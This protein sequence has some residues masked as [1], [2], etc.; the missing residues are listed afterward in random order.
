M[1]EPPPAEP[2]RPPKSSNP[3]RVLKNPRFARLFSAGVASTAGTAIGQV[4]IVWFVYS[5]TKSAIDVALVGISYFAAITVFSLL[6]GTL[7]DRQDRRRLMILA[8]IGRCATLG[9]MTAVLYVFGFSVFVVLVATFLVGALTTVFQPAERAL[10]PTLIEKDEIADANGLTQ[11][12]TSLAQFVA[13]ATGGALIAAVGALSALGLNSI[14]FLVSAALLAGIVTR[15]ITKGPGEVS[16]PRPG[17][18]ED[19]REGFRYIA[20]NRGLLN[21]TIMSGVENVFLSIFGTFAVIYSTAVLGDNATA[22]GAFVALF[23]LGIGL[24]SLLVGRVGSVRWAG[25]GWLIGGALE[26]FVILSLVYA[27]DIVLACAGSFFLGVLLGFT[28]TTWLST[29]QLVVPGEMQGRYFGLDQLGSF[30]TIPLGQI[31]R[32][33]PDQC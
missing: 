15:R 27:N 17:F 30:A 32:G 1:T 2:A 29:V 31:P 8:D 18:L 19:A 11:I 5:V 16:A 3:L 24:G 12:T 4:A 25:R 6:A 10:T 7:V 26:G 9:V 28:N 13:N 20:S 21:M 33:L 23:A 14:T 22:Y